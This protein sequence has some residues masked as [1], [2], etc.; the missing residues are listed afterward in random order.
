MHSRRVLYILQNDK[1]MIKSWILG[2]LLALQF[3]CINAQDYGGLA[4]GAG[5]VRRRNNR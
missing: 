5:L 2:I 1:T 3:L 4:R